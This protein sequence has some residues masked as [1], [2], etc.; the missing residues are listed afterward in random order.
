MSAGIENLTIRTVI[1]DT[2]ELN[3]GDQLRL[4]SAKIDHLTKSGVLVTGIIVSSNNT[5]KVVEI[6]SIY[7]S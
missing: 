3:T 6:D 4:H 7:L 2:D 1:K 5:G